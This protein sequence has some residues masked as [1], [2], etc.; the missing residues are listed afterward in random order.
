LFHGTSLS[1]T[2][3]AVRRAMLQTL[4]SAIGQLINQLHSTHNAREGHKQA[5]DE[6]LAEQAAFVCS[7]SRS[8]SSSSASSSASSSI[9]SSSSA[10]S[11]SAS[12][13]SGAASREHE[14]RQFR[15]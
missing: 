2:K 13:S 7:S 12:S 15:H 9:A 3:S 14:Q 1:R 4:D 10:S 6:L 8:T 11:S 5:L